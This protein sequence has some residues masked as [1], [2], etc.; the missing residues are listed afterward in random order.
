MSIYLMLSR[1]IA[2]CLVIFV[3]ELVRRNKLQ[4]S[5]SILWIIIS[6]L[7]IIL[8]VSESILNHFAAWIGIDYA[9][10]LLFLVAIVFLLALSIKF[11]IIHTLQ[12]KKI[13]MLIQELSLLKSKVDELENRKK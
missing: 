13:T 2:V 10:S 5:Y 6:I 9:P 3:I 8:T 4:E 1:I 11:C 12:N 7:I